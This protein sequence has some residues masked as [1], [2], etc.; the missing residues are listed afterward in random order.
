[1]EREARRARERKI[2]ARMK[3]LNLF[4]FHCLTV[5]P[6]G[7]EKGE[8]ERGNESETLLLKM[9]SRKAVLEFPDVCAQHAR[10]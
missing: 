2:A 4:L 5:N 1:M 6:R 3:S 10:S 7:R 9:P 8:R